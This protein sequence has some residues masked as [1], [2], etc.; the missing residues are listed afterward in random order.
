MSR[1]EVR[2]GK[3]PHRIRAEDPKRER[4]PLPGAEGRQTH[5]GWERGGFLWGKIGRKKK[6]MS[7]SEKG[8]G[9][10]DEHHMGPAAKGPDFPARKGGKKKKRLIG[11][12][13]STHD[14]GGRGEDLP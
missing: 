11:G 7:P 4:S 8:K 6:K 9:Q 12:K 1:G 2:G 5:W 10:G 3:I 14:Q 13:E